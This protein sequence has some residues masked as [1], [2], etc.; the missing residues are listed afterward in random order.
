MKML[1]ALSY[2]FLISC[3]SVPFSLAIDTDIYVSGAGGGGEPPNIL[4]IFDNSANW[5]SNSGTRP[6]RDIEHE[7]L[8]RF[9]DEIAVRVSDPLN[10]E[11]IDHNIAIMGAT[12]AN[13]NGGGKPL[14]YFAPIRKNNASSSMV[15]IR[16]IKEM[17]YCNKDKMKYSLYLDCIVALT[18]PDRDGIIP[19]SQKFILE[20]DRI[21]AGLV[22]GVGENYANWD[23]RVDAL[24][25]STDIGFGTWIA[26]LTKQDQDSVYEGALPTAN[27]AK[28]ATQMHEA[29]LWYQGDRYR[30]GKADG[31][32]SYDMNAFMPT[33]KPEYK[34]PIS[35]YP[36]DPSA[37]TSRDPSAEYCGR[38][39]IVFLGNGGPDSGENNPAE[40]LLSSIGSATDIID[41][42]VNDKFE[43][44]WA[45]EYARYLTKTDVNDTVTGDQH[46]TTH[47]VDV[48]DPD[49]EK[50]TATEL[51]ARALLKSMASAG[52][53]LY[54]QAKDPESIVEGLLEIVNAVLAVNDVFAASALPVSVNVR[55]TNLNQ[56]YIGVFRPDEDGRP[57]WNGNM[58]MYKL[59]YDETTGR[60]FLSDADGAEA[61]NTATG[62]IT[63]DARSFWT[64]N[65]TF[66]NY[67]DGSVGEGVGGASDSPDGDM[68]EKGAVAQNLRE[69]LALG[70]ARNLLTC[71]ACTV[72]G[73]LQNFSTSN[74]AITEN[75]LGLESPSGANRTGIIR[76]ASGHNE[77]NS[78]EPGYIDPDTLINSKARPSIHGDVLH[79]R[80]AVINYGDTDGN[81]A[82]EEEVYVFYG[83]NDGWLRAVKGGTDESA[84][85]DSG[86]EK[87]AFVAPE[88]WEEFDTLRDNA[89]MK[90][91][92]GNADQSLK[93]FFID[94]V[95]GS[96]VQYTNGVVDST[97]DKQAIIY[98][99]MRRG[100]KF[101]YALDVSNPEVPKF[102]WTVKKGDPGFEELGQT[103]SAPTIGKVKFDGAEKT[104]LVFGLGYD[105]EANDTVRS[106]AGNALATDEGR[107]IIMVDAFDGSLVWKVSNA[108][109][110]TDTNLNVAAIKYAVAADLSVIDRDK[111]GF[112]DRIYFGDTGGQLWRIDVQYDDRKKWAATKL[113]ELTGG[114]KFLSA[115]DA[116]ASTD[117]NDPFDAVVI[118]SGDRE[119]PFEKSI[120]NYIIVLKDYD[121]K[122]GNSGASTKS[123]SELF[124]ATLTT[125]FKS[126]AV[127]AANGYYIELMAAGE[128]GISKPSIVNSIVFLNTFEPPSIT[129]CSSLGT[130]RIYQFDFMTSEAT[131]DQDG[132]GDKDLED[133]W[134]AVEGGGLLPDPVPVIVDIDGELVEAIISGTQVEQFP[135]TVL[136]K[137]QQTFWFKEVDD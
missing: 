104:V 117:Q 16:E 109:S 98:A 86:E 84:G 102:L 133:R 18:D 114:Q 95:I 47:T 69:K 21:K 10:E 97:K 101:I 32:L 118:V 66:W 59:G 125:D 33:D 25:A 99:T 89:V 7:A 91:A 13:T 41:I 126:D 55:G 105:P 103:W 48:F 93:P 39:H 35:H 83:A 130:A 81:P 5:N 131:T 30:S 74:A 75:D 106:Q 8:Y 44:N 132:D 11:P 127:R 116:A 90:D 43:A 3:I 56:V 62:F 15:H 112:I 100:G 17:L 45:D 119:N 58:K 22:T 73:T 46:I 19:S 122:V 88:H 52:E 111:N 110:N 31:F 38:N 137:R 82:T 51:G 121:Q 60:V 20:S 34:S 28:Y 71:A 6:K 67:I 23:D 57:R 124:N 92:F 85:S 123:L 115:P 94:G 53:G 113:F 77:S 9:V 129:S 12:E 135:N 24:G 27:R 50:G 65:S 2:T 68:V 78:S 108:G 96:Y 70:N 29:Y 128:K 37:A 72:N 36:E 136:E 107:G 80:P 63:E 120:P 49:I 40:A 4:F 76:W 54:I 79:S 61:A 42:R 1:K 134:T 14:Y 87:W 64:H 26:T